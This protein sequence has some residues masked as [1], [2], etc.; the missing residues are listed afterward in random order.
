[1]GGGK[2]KMQVIK[3]LKCL[4]FNSQF[5]RGKSM[6]SLVVISITERLL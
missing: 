1:M 5:A 4:M 3:Q 2:K 6:T